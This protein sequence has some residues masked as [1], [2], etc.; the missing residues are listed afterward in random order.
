M[1]PATNFCA[2][3]TAR[4]SPP[5]RRHG[6]DVNRQVTR[7][8]RRCLSPS[9]SDSRVSTSVDEYDVRVRRGVSGAR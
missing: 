8:G 6:D 5:H 4:R 3:P 9:R 7:S 2:L 1:P